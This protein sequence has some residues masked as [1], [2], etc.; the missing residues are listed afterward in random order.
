[1]LKKALFLVM[2][3]ALSACGGLAGD[4]QIV[5][6]LTP[7]GGSAP[8][9][10]DLAQGAQT[11]ALRCTSCHGV[12][13]AGQGELVQSGQVGRIPSFLD[14]DH[15]RQQTLE[16]YFN[17]ITNGNL[18]NLMP[19]WKDSL[20]EQERWNVAQYVLTLHQAQGAQSTPVL[21]GDTVIIE[22][23]VNNGTAN[24]TIPT[25]A[26]VAL[27]Y[28]NEEAG[29]T[30]IN[31][32]INADGTYRFENVPVQPSFAYIVLV[33]YR[34][35]IFN[36]EVVEVA[37]LAPVTELPVTVY[38]LTEDPFIISITDIKTFV[39]PFFLQDTAVQD[40]LLFTQTFTYENSSD[41]LFSLSQNNIV[42]SLLVQLPPGAIVVNVTRNPRF[43]VIQEQFAVIDTQPIKPGE[44]TIELVYFVPYSDGAVI[45]QPFGNPFSGTATLT[46]SPKS[47]TLSEGEGWTGDLT[48]PQVNVYTR[49]YTAGASDTLRYTLAGNLA[50]NTSDNP[51]VITTDNIGII[52]G[53]VLAVLVAIVGA[54]IFTR[55]PEPTK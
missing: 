25:D 2:L 30:D 11:F 31:A 28:G 33:T 3:L 19:P 29:L 24:S 54:M 34:E 40:G 21:V 53:L 13:G 52:I 15:M 50:N 17:I 36:S 26:P 8:A 35:R 22:G 4:V 1:M 18:E 5:A 48:P 39:E 27:R 55:R 44:H 16:G 46:L 32:T 43:L 37:N 10:F 7:V 12:N 14:A 47:L 45:E 49:T 23:R 41:R 51:N 42:V 20:S 9:L 38:E 6:T